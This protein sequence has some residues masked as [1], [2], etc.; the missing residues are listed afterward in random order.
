MLANVRM[1]RR[2]LKCD[3]ECHGKIEL[4]RPIHKAL[5]IQ[6]GSQLG[7][8]CLMS[9]LCRADGPGASTIFLLCFGRIVA[10]FAKL[11]ADGMN[12]W[13]VHHVEPHLG[14]VGQSLFA[15][16]ERAMSTRRVCGGSRKDLVPCAE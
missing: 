8:N 1:I 6:N 15:V 3:V 11:D 4:F 12:R 9:P 14:D 2:H 16:G 13:H 10:T 7:M 5:E